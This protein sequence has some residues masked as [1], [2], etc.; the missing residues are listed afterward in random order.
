M[1]LSLPVVMLQPLTMPVPY[2]SSLPPA[3][4][5]S[6]LLVPGGVPIGFVFLSYL[7]MLSLTLYVESSFLE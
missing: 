5:S 1:L 7:S 2:S 4:Q 6:M 3:V